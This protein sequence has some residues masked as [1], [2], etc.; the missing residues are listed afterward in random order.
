MEREISF[1]SY[2]ADF[3]EQGYRVHVVTRK[4]DDPYGKGEDYQ[5]NEMFILYE[6][7]YGD[8]MGMEP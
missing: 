4:N 3:N 7:A 8:Q 6:N 1:T 5:N 2:E